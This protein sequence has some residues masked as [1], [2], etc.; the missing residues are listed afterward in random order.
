MGQDKIM[1]T[2]SLKNYIHKG[3]FEKYLEECKNNNVRL[4][5]PFGVR[6]EVAESLDNETDSQ[7][8]HN[9]LKQGLVQGVVIKSRHK[10]DFERDFKLLY[11]KLNSVDNELNN[12]QKHAIALSLQQG[13]I[14]DTK[15]S[16]IIR[17]LSTIKT[18]PHLEKYLHRLY[19]KGKLEFITD[20]TKS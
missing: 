14:I 8:W 12:T 5:I 10:Y 16:R 7:M 1:Y 6:K 13:I 9:T 4:Y 15:N 11:H 20:N 18:S 17:A 2:D 19:S 3:T